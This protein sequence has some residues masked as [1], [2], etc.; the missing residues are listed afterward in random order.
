MITIIL[1]STVYINL[2]NN[3]NPNFL[4]QKDPR[5]R[6]NDYVTTVIKWLEQTQFNIILVENSGYI[7][8]ELSKEKELYKNRFEII[9]YKET[10]LEE[11][12]YLKFTDSKG[13]S[14]MFSID[15]AYKHSKLIHSSKFIIKITARFFISEL[16]EYLKHFNLDEYECLTQN[17]RDR[18]EMVGCHYKFFSHIFAK[19]LTIDNKYAQYVEGVWK[20]RTSKHKNLLCKEFKIEKT[21]RGGVSEYY[22]TI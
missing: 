16:E 3:L 9:T 10:D 15:Y 22:D 18:C 1:T 5:E 13:A 20:D 12:S 14:E 21:Q 6:I 11:A 4:Y 19:Y 7:Y 8:Q 2:N 17:N